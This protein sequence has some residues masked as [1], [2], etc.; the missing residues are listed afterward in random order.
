M[1]PTGI[2]T[3]EVIN[4]NPLEY[5]VE[6][7]PIGSQSY[8]PTQT[9]VAVP[10]A[11][12]GGYIGSTVGISMPE[13]GSIVLFVVPSDAS[14]NMAY[15]LGHAKEFSHRDSSPDYYSDIDQLSSRLMPTGFF[16]GS[17]P[18]DVLPGDLIISNS[19][20]AR[21]SV[22]S[23]GDISIESD[24]AKL[25]VGSILGEG[26][27]SIETSELS[28]TTDSMDIDIDKTGAVITAS[29]NNSTRNIVVNGDAP[30]DDLIVDIGRTKAFAISYTGGSSDALFSIDK[31][32]E[33]LIK[34]SKV[35]INSSG[36][37]T[38][39]GVTIIPGDDKYQVQGEHSMSAE[40]IGN[41]SN[42]DIKLY[43][44]GNININSGTDVTV[45]TGG[46]YK[47]QVSGPSLLKN[48]PTAIIPGLNDGLVMS[49][50]SGSVVIQS[51]SS[52]P[53]TTALSK[54]QI[55]LESISGGDII[56][57]SASGLGAGGTSGAIVISSPSPASFTGAG[58]AGNYGIVLNSPMCLL[59]NYPG[60][61]LTAPYLPNV[62]APPIPL[63]GA[64][65]LIKA[66]PLITILQALATAL[67]AT[68]AAPAGAALVSSLTALSPSLTTKFVYGN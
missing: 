24:S 2:Y 16:R 57:Q 45:Y 10:L 49:C 46:V 41:Y 1:L 42:S 58:G 44:K 35:V 28:V 27:V 50:D 47:K 60:I 33:I 13:I 56:M 54:P 59:G 20:G 9:L 39:N 34:G 3:G 7:K 29:V 30:P 48:G 26:V 8:R 6:V 67:S 18:G 61:D 12:H 4:V 66:T 25:S 40:L 55:R 22:N 21:L 17:S 5:S 63:V 36:S 23:G 14:S 65:L 53:G 43:A 19:E 52:I 37:T 51:G 11:F 15:I 31:N 62:F 38:A 68:P 32:G 64:D